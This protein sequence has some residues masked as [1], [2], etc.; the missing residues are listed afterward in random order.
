[1]KTPRPAGLGIMSRAGLLV[2]RIPTSSV[3]MPALN[4]ASG[5]LRTIRAISRKELEAK[6]YQVEVL[7]VDNGSED[8]TGELAEHLVGSN[9][10]H[11]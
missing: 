4:E 9:F 6:G 11:H 7:V 8:R 1:M 2:N 10:R 3:V 5:I